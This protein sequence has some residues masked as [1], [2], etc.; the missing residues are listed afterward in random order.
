MC[1]AKV[2]EVTA[3]T[4]AALK[5][6]IQ[7]K[8]PGTYNLNN[9][10]SVNSNV[11]FGSESNGVRIVSP[12]NPNLDGSAIKFVFANGYGITISAMNMGFEH[13]AFV[14]SSPSSYTSEMIKILGSHMARFEHCDFVAG[15]GT[16]IVDDN[17]FGTHIIDPLVSLDGDYGTGFLLRNH[18]NGMT[19]DGACYG[20][21]IYNGQLALLL[22]GAEGLVCNNLMSYL[23]RH[24]CYIQPASNGSV[25]N[26]MFNGCNFDSVHDSGS[27]VSVKGDLGPYSVGYL[28]FNNCWMYSGTTGGPC[29]DIER[30]VECL[31]IVGGFARCDNGAWPWYYATVAPSQLIRAHIAP[32][33]P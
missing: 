29:F 20:R 26:C 2:F 14:A 16:A 1:M 28:M 4:I 31:S 19:I 24:G 7:S 17:S 11:T 12:S 13:C 8:G 6:F 27:C 23:T 30:P 21:G 15:R 3:T 18:S 22:N 33:M 10:I 25:F 5:T 32:N 9:N